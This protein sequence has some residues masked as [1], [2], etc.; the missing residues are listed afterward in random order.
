M[1]AVVTVTLLLFMS[2]LTTQSEFILCLSLRAQVFEDGCLIPSKDLSFLPLRIPRTLGF[3]PLAP[4]QPGLLCSSLWLVSNSSDAAQTLHS[5]PKFLLGV[6]SA[7]ASPD[8]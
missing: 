3:L 7:P 5:A 8:L 1:A 2:S 4:S 6:L